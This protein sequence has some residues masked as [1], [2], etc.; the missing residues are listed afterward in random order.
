M[1]AQFINPDTGK[2]SAVDVASWIAPDLGRAIDGT[3]H[4][5]DTDAGIYRPR[6]GLIKA[7]VAAALGDRY[8]ATVLGQVEAHLLNVTIPEVGPPVIPGEGYLDHIVLMNG[9]YYWKAH[10]FGGHDPRL[11]ALNRLQFRYDATATCPVFRDWLRVTFEDNAQVIRHVWEVLGYLLMTGNPEQIAF[12]FYG[13]GG[14]GKGTLMRVLE[15]MIGA[16][17]MAA[18]T[19]HQIAEGKFELATL[20]GKMINL[21]GDVSSRYIENP[22]VFKTITGDDYVTTSHKFGA[23]FKFKSYAVPVFSVNN[24]FRTSDSSEGWRRRWLALDFNVPLRGKFAGFNEQDLYAEA[25]GIFNEAMIALRRLMERTTRP[26]FD[27][28]A[29]VQEA[30]RKMLDEADPFM[31]WFN[32]DGVLHDVEQSDVRDTVYQHYVKWSRRNGYQAM[33]SGPFGGRL[34]QVGVTSAG[35]RIGGKMSRV[36]TGIGVMIEPHDA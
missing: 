36:Y 25:P 8:S 12:L 7:R 14:N 13:E 33:S 29:A 19:L 11:G 34:K 16:D 31:M 21:A 4:E 35:R 3:Y 6:E 10:E 28:P 17:N 9:V 2:L 5:Y 15:N 24:Y 23:P 32:S 26:R 20:Y 22:E 18:L 27:P 1:T 30:T